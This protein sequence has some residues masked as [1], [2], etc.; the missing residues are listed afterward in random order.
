MLRTTLRLR[1]H[2]KEL[3]VPTRR[4]DHIVQCLKNELELRKSTSTLGICRCYKRGSIGILGNSMSRN[5]NNPQNP[6]DASHARYDLSGIKELKHIDTQS[7]SL[8]LRL[9]LVCGQQSSLP[10][11]VA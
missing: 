4:S 5:M 1:K 6:Q 8:S 10:Y 2:T 7:T 3:S 11:T 9:S